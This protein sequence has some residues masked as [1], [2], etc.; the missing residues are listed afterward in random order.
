MNFA[1]P[2]WKRFL[3]IVL[4][5][6]LLPVIVP[7][8]LLV[9]LVI[10]CVSEGPVLFRQERIGYQGRRFL[11]IK[12]RTMKPSADAGVH[13]GHLERLIESG[14]PLVKMDFQGDPRLIPFGLALRSSGLDELPQ[15]VNVLRGEMSVVGPRPCVPY[16]YARYQQWQC[17]R[18][19]TLPGLTGLW[20]VSGKN[21]TTFAEMTRLDIDYVR[22]R[23][24]RLDLAIILRTFPA[25]VGQMRDTRRRARRPAR[26]K[27]TIVDAS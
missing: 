9:M 27:Q 3:D 19:N 7:L 8:T 21:R 1:I 11:C 14:Q 12:F 26:I 18:F 24:L 13:R 6:V 23:S 5:I 20:Q 22:R 17:E 25:L 10:R 4:V 2:Q 15:I 16:E